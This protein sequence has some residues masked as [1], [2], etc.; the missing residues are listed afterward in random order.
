MRP[1]FTLIQKYQSTILHVLTWSIFFAAHHFGSGLW[2]QG[3]QIGP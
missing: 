3:A 1:A 2:R